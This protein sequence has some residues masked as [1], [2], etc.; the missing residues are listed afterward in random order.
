M[1]LQASYASSLYLKTTNA[2]QGTDLAIHTSIRGPNGSNTY[3]T[4]LISRLSDS[5]VIS[6]SLVRLI[7]HLGITYILLEVPL[8][9]RVVKVGN[10]QA[11]S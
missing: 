6:D 11:V 4:R 3:E 1:I 8:G 2:K 7:S 5:L 10:V 9:G